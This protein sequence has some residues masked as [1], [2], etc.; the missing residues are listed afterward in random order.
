[1]TTFNNEKP[2]VFISSTAGD[3][4]E[5]RKAALF[6]VWKFGWEG[7][8]ME[9]FGASPRRTIEECRGTLEKCQVVL[10]LVAHRQGTVPTPEEGGNGT[11]SFTALELEHAR[12]CGIPVLIMMASEKWPIGDGEQDPQKRAWV[13]RFRRSLN[14]PAEMFDFE[15]HPDLPNFRTKL[16][17]VLLACD[18][19]LT[20]R[21]MNS[22]TLTAPEDLERARVGLE[23]GNTIV[24]LGSGI[25]GNRALGPTALA[26][27]LPGDDE[28]AKDA[29]RETVATA[30]Q[31]CEVYLGTRLNFLEALQEVFVKQMS[32][33]TVPAAAQMMVESDFKLI[34]STTGD[35]LLENLLLEKYGSLSVVTHVMHAE[36]PEYDR[37]IAVLRWSSPDGPPSIEYRGA[38]EVDLQGERRVVY[39]LLGSVFLNTLL[40]PNHEVDTVVVTEMDHVAFLTQLE[41]EKTQV[42]TIFAR[43]LSRRTLLLLGYPL[44]R[45]HYRLV[46]HGFGALGQRNHRSALL[47]VR[48]PRSAIERASWRSLGA[49]LI[50][51]GL[52][53]FVRGVRA[54]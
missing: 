22:G 7:E 41:N 43:D 23:R 50:E 45:W 33:A 29:E 19:Q 25:F 34:I 6:E 35:M 42:P 53:D 39:K 3:L 31:Y 54:A 30:A 47:A 36:D 20:R 18:E 2:K 52:D 49:R 46:M 5:Y 38:D 8:G 44:D 1:M 24:I 28:L 9:R 4:E 51:V 32:E 10:L 37:K 15:D 40:A 16:R 13:D 26:K 11:D 27:A 14:Q 17:K 21:P 12:A 48:S